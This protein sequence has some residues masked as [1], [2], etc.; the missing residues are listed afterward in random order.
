M[1]KVVH[2]GRPASGMGDE[3]IQLRRFI[4]QVAGHGTLYVTNGNRLC[5]FIK[6]REFDFYETCL[7][8]ISKLQEFCCQYFGWLDFTFVGA[9]KAKEEGIKESPSMEAM[10]REIVDELVKRS[11]CQSK[12]DIFFIRLFPNVGPGLNGKDLSLSFVYD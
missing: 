7:G 4:H 1:L 5:K 11:S 8:D 9:E 6:S 12:E 2:H 10:E 3:P